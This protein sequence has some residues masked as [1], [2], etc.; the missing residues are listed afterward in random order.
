MAERLIMKKEC[1]LVLLLMAFTHI[2]FAQKV[3]LNEVQNKVGETVTVCGKINGGVHLPNATN[4]PTLLNMGGSFPNHL[5]TLVIFGENLKDFPAQPE[6]YFANQQ[7]CVTGLVIDY[8]GKPEIILR[9]PGQIQTEAQSIAAT[10]NISKDTANK[11]SDITYN[12]APNK[13]SVYTGSASNKP[14]GNSGSAPNKP[15]VNSGNA[16]NKP[17]VTTG[18]TSNNPVTNPYKAPDIPVTGTT[19]KIGTTPNKPVTTYARATQDDIKLT[20]DVYMRSG[21]S[22]DYPLVTTVK[23]GTVVSVLFSSNGWSQVV[24]KDTNSNLQGYIKNN[25][26]K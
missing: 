19:S 9:S 7:V 18:K 25:V 11:S 22:F 6:I 10:P 17:V 14:A 26:L 20:Q 8:K 2:C 24:I 15:P 3:T 1:V 21:P 5:L 16:S 23:T 4:T 13:P 12:G